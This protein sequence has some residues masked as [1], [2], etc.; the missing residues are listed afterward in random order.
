[1]LS[2]IM[3]YSDDG[4]PNDDAI[5]SVEGWIFGQNI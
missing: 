4:L 2:V 3:G 1:M 5:K